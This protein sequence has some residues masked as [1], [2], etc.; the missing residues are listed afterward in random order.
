MVLFISKTFSDVLQHINTKK[1]TPVKQEVT[2]IDRKT[3]V[4]AAT[5][6]APLLSR[7]G[8]AQKQ[9]HVDIP[10]TNMRQTIAK[11]LSQSK[12]RFYTNLI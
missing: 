1:L 2:K 12:V 11:R 10:L 8:R 4:K 7:D 5:K 6:G 9:T 3:E